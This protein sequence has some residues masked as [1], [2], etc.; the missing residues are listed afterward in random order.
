MSEPTK[1][2]PVPATVN[3]TPVCRESVREA[4][5]SVCGVYAREAMIVI[6]N[7]VAAAVVALC[8]VFYA[9]IRATSRMAPATQRRSI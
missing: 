8:A 4:P 9:P 1:T 6:M 3:M 5:V 7:I 2:A